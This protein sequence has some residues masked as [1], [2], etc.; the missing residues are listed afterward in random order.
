MLKIYNYIKINYSDDQVDIFALAEKALGIRSSSTST[1]V[2]DTTLE[3]TK[4]EV[5]SYNNL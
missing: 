1:N 2:S 3:E 5:S 4:S